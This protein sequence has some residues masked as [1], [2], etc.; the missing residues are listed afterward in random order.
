MKQEQFIERYQP[1]WNVF[2]AWLDYQQT[3]KKERERQGLQEPQL[4][5]PA[6]YRQLC[7]HLALAQSRMYSPL[8]IEQLNQLVIRG[9]NHLYTSRL[10]FL[11]RIAEFYL[12]DLPRLVRREIKPL[13]LSC[14][15]FFGSFFAVLIAI[16]LE[17]ELVYSV[18]DGE[19]VA[20]MEAMYDPVNR[21]SRLGRERE[22]DSDV[23]MFGFYIR[24]N[25][26]IGFQVFAGGL[27]YGIGSLFFLLYNGL[28]IGAVAGHL[29]QIGYIET[30]W[31]FVA[32]HSAFELTAIV[33]SG[34]A[35]F[36]LAQAL[37]MPGRKAR[38]LA[39]LDNSQDAI[40]IVYGAATLFIMAAFVE[41]FWSSQTWIPVM[42]KYAV[43]ISLWLVVLA[44]F[45]LAGR[46]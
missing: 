18:I 45:T 30:F 14:L 33:L 32:G 28:V 39:L 17:P 4:D 29:T 44:Y 12:R 25:T 11:H 22:A 9:H 13:L 23:F 41:A 26:G 21:E 24:N 46:K 8:L 6:A 36:K 1:L 43:G 10:H 37:V 31:G 2:E 42:I 35:G 7:H 19:Q 27:L 34:A 5:F 20:G 15:L 40:K 3:A 16:Q 38:L